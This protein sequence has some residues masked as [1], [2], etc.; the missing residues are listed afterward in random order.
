MK[1]QMDVNTRNRR[2]LSTSDNYPK[3]NHQILQ[4]YGWLQFP[5]VHTRFIFVLIR[6]AR[7]ILAPVFV[8]LFS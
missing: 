1:L 6:M 7:V 3:M 2:V 4:N 5:I 8:K